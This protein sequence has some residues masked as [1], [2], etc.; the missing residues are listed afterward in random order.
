MFYRVNSYCYRYILASTHDKP[1]TSLISTI[2][3]QNESFLTNILGTLLMIIR[4]HE[5]TNFIG[6]YF[7]KIEWCIPESWVD[8]TIIHKCFSWY[9]NFSYLMAFINNKEFENCTLTDSFH[10]SFNC[11]SFTTWNNCKYT[12]WLNM[13]SIWIKY[14]EGHILFLIQ[15]LIS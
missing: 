15:F 8:C 10:S 11:S 5:A 7:K 6:K 14:W 12:S 2:C 9:P 4:Y 13:K 1:Q 3:Y